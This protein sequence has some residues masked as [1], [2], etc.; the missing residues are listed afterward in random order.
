MVITGRCGYVEGKTAVL[1]LVM[2]ILTYL[3][4]DSVDGVVLVV[5]SAAVNHVVECV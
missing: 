1:R 5:V 3:L 2:I 4:N